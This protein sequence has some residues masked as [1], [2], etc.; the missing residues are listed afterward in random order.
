MM[1]KRQ[2]GFYVSVRL[3]KQG[4]F[5]SELLDGPWPNAESAHKRAGEMKARRDP[6]AAYRVVEVTDDGV[7][8]V[9]RDSES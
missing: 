9:V 2:P 3:E 4:L 5:P 1:R 6:G 8:V 7:T